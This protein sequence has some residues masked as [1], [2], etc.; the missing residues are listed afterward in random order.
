MLVQPSFLGTDNSYLVAALK[1]QPQR[2]R[3]VVV[4][5]P[6]IAQSELDDLSTAGVVGV[7]LNLIGVDLPDLK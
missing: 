3:G 5:D 4:V 2:L 7:R 1:E 6:M